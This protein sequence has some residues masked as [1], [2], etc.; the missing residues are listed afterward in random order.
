VSSFALAPKLNILPAGG[1]AVVKPADVF[2]FETGVS[3]LSS[4]HGNKVN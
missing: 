4:I 1:V 2:L 3:S